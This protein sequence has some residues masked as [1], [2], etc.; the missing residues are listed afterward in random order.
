MLSLPRNTHRYLIEP[1]SKV[2][3]IVRS[4]RKRFITFIEKI[5]AGEK[6]VL[7]KMLDTIES[8]AR[9]TTGRNLRCLKLQ[10]LDNIG[11]SYEISENEVWRIKLAEDI[12]SARMG[13]LSTILS[14][15]ELEQICIFVCS[16]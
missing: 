10:G 2:K 5:K 3:H 13:R 16:S 14:D 7:K 12:I 8:D 4:L 9:S 11:T 15:E 6:A 1:L